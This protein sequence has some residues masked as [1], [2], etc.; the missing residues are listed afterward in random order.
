MPW[1][2][3]LARMRWHGVGFLTADWHLTQTWNDTQ[4]AAASSVAE[5]PDGDG[6]LLCT[7]R[8]LPAAAA[9]ALADALLEHGAL[10][11]A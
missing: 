5:N 10:S 11:A 6:T 9:D 2:S 3:L 8:D 1:M 7:V 4:G